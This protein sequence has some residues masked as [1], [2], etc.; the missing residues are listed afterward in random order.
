MVKLIKLVGN[1]VEGGSTPSKVINNVFSDS[2]MVQPGSRIAL[3]ACQ[4][5]FDDTS[6]GIQ[7]DFTVPDGSN[8][9][10]YAIGAATGDVVN[11]EIPQPS[12]ARANDSGNYKNATLVVSAMAETA[13]STS[14]PASTED[15]Y[16]GLHHRY[17]INGDNKTV[18]QTFKADVEDAQFQ[19]WIEAADGKTVALSTTIDSSKSLTLLTAGTGYSAGPATTTGG[20]GTGL[21]VELTVDAGAV[22]DIKMVAGGDGAY[23]DGETITVSTGGTGCTFQ[24]HACELNQAEIVPLVSSTQTFKLDSPA[25]C[26]WAVRPLDGDDDIA[27]GLQ[28][29]GNRKY[30]ALLNGT[31]LGTP[32]AFNATINDEITIVKV[33]KTITITADGVF[34]VYSQTGDLG[35]SASG[36]NFITEQNFMNTLRIGAGQPLALREASTQTLAGLDQGDGANHQITLIWTSDENDQASKRIPLAAQLGFTYGRY[37]NNGAPTTITSESQAT[38]LI[39]NSGVLVC[40]DGLDLDTYMGGVTRGPSNV[41]ILD[42]LF[43]D[44]NKPRTISQIVSFPMPLDLKNEREVIIRDLRVRFLDSNLKPRSFVGNPS[45]VLELYGPK[46]SS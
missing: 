32:S 27:Y 25:A 26:T 29:L 15:R 3:R 30:Q 46:E 20:S 44:P 34:G 24:L 21:V 13:N 41:N 8:T 40:I 17:F 1:S 16:S 19:N 22:T 43:E 4:V 10:S 2:I 12:A 35:V 6:T 5:N 38:G 23:V 11:V 31:E 14:P 42:V 18:I 7:R 33:G 39:A 36:Y 9:F 28:I 37:V 45:V